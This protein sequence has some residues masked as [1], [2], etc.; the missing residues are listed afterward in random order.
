MRPK[1][2]YLEIK[3]TIPEA[4]VSMQAAQELADQLRFQ[5]QEIAKRAWIFARHANRETITVE[6]VKLAIREDMKS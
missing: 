4:R 5:C 1:T 2:V 6:D 3:K